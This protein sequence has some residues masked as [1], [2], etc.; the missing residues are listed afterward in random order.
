MAS[1][2]VSNTVYVQHQLNESVLLE[3]IL[4]TEAGTNGWGDPKVIQ[5]PTN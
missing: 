2:N 4:D 5:I 3:E 1:V